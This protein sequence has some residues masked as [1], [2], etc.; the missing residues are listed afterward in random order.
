MLPSESHRHDPAQTCKGLPQQYTLAKVRTGRLH[1]VEKT[2]SPVDVE[3]VLK[4]RSLRIAF[5][6]VCDLK[7]REVIGYEAL[8]RFPDWAGHHSP[9]VVRAGARAR[10]ATAPRA[11]RGDDRHRAAGAPREGRLLVGQ[12]RRRQQ[13][14]PRSSRSSARRCLLI[15]SCSR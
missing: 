10:P 1:V 2:E 15:A 7:T 13:P 3:Q 11:P 9:A 4:D 14:P 6:P 8:A 5:Q 12:P